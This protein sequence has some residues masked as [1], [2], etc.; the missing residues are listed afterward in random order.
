MGNVLV[1]T[2]RPSEAIRRYEMAARLD[3][4]DAMAQ[5]NLAMVLAQIGRTSDAIVHFQE[6]VRLRP[7]DTEARNYLRQLQALPPGTRAGL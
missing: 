2:G 7:D 1:Q 5:Y 4:N 3:P 6:A